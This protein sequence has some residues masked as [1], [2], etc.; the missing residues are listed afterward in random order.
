MR[1]IISSAYDGH[2][3]SGGYKQCLDFLSVISSCSS[4]V[5]N[6]CLNQICSPF[7]RFNVFPVGGRSTVIKLSNGDLWVAASTPLD[8]DTK[9]KLEDLG[10]KVKYIIGL[11]A[12]HNLYLRKGVIILPRDISWI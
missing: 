5:K 4:D 3:Y 12:V 10:G 1:T 9:S 11:D 8:A 2:C 6:T 7:Y